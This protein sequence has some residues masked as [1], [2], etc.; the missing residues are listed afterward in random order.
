MP[1]KTFGN[2]LRTAGSTRSSVVVSVLLPDLTHSL[3]YR[4]TASRFYIWQNWY[5]IW[6]SST[7]MMFFGYGLDADSKNMVFS[8][9]VAH[10]HNFYLNNIF[11]GGVIGFSLID[12]SCHGF[13]LTKTISVFFV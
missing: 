4:G 7:V 2:T 6:P 10:F 13:K 9:T 5:D 8:S 1:Q 12:L 3:I 11:Y